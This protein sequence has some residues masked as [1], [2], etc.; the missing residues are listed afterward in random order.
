MNNKRALF[1]IVGMYC[2]S[3]KPIVEKQLNNEKGIKKIDINYVT[4]SIAVDFD[5]SILVEKQI[6]NKLENSG[7]KF[8]SVAR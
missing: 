4:D 2:A 1:R 5:P 8:A 7:Y 3:C 6:K